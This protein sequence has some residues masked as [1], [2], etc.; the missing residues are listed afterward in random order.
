MLQVPLDLIRTVL[1]ETFKKKLFA[2]HFV[3]TAVD[4]SYNIR[5]RKKCGSCLELVTLSQLQLW[6]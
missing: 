3:Y 2:A 1:I 6:G 4:I 5:V